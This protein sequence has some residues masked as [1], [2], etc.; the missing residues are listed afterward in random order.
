MVKKIENIVQNEIMPGFMG[1]MVH[2]EKFTIAF[3][4]IK[5]GSILP[6]HTHINEQSTQVTMGILELTINGK[7]QILE[8]GD[9]VVIPPNVVH[10]GKAITYCELT[11]TFCPTR[12]DYK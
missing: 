5:E 3:W 4:E 1:R 10:K 9:I 2:A 6:E 12:E 8:K 11:D 7:T